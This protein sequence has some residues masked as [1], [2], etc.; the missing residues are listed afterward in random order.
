MIRTP[1][2]ASRWSSLRALGLHQQA[3][4]THVA[5]FLAALAGGDL[6]AR[7]DVNQAGLFAEYSQDVNATLDE[8]LE[9]MKQLRAQAVTV[10]ADSEQL[11]ATSRAMAASAADAAG[12]AVA[13]TQAAQQVTANVHSVATAAGQ[14]GVGLQEVAVTA[15]QAAQVANEAVGIAH[16]ANTT[17]VRLGEASMQVESIVNLIDTVARQSHLLALNATIEASRAGETSSG[18]AVVARE[19]K[20]LAKQTADAT[21]V[22]AEHNTAIQDEARAAADAIGN[23]T[24]IAFQI[25]LYQS[26]IATAVEEQTATMGAMIR[27]ATEAASASESIGAAIHAVETAVE[28]ASH[29]ARDAAQASAE[30]A[31]HA[32]E[33]GALATVLSVE[34]PDTAT[35]SSTPPV[36]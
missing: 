17:V 29:S 19:M 5:Q 1:R 32:V 11:T 35:T 30:L 36:R 24:E 3:G 14:F 7:L 2:A 28:S 6:S 26:T 25:D 10:C 21:K 27:A 34:A 4:A 15:A 18:F 33:L 23:F 8:A 16:G 31:V 12:Q 20:G 13:M 9:T 22:I